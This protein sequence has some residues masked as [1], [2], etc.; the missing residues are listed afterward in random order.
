MTV[1]RR[2]GHS[3]SALVMPERTRSF[4]SWQALSGSP[5]IAK[6]R[7]APLEVC[8]DLDR[9]RFEADER[10]GDGARKH[11]LDARRGTCAGGARIAPSSSQSR[12]LVERCTLDAAGPDG[13]GL[14]ADFEPGEL[15]TKGQPGLRSPPHAPG[16]LGPDRL[17]RALRIRGRCGP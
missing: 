2:S 15:G 11:A 1:I 13:N 7:H 16:L 4:A 14:E 3:S 8:L 12:A 9:P 6:R 5:T 17:E 10:M